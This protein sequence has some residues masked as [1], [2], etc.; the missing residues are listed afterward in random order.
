MG[1]TMIQFI[2]S[3]AANNGYTLEDFEAIFSYKSD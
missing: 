2:K 1:K 3:S